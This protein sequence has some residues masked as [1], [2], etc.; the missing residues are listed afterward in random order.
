MNSPHKLHL[1]I[2]AVT[3]TTK[4]GSRTIH[5]RVA[6]IAYARNGNVDNPTVTYEY[7]VREPD[8]KL[9]DYGIS[10]MREAKIVSKADTVDAAIAALK[11]GR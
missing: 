6:H 9:F 4:V 11:E 3:K 7:D 1:Q 8:S 5:Q 10:T 2:G